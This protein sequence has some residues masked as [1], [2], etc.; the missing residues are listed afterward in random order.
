MR[1]LIGGIAMS[2]AISSGAV[3]ISFLCDR[4][5]KMQIDARS[6]EHF[7]CHPALR[8]GRSGQRDEKKRARHAVTKSLIAR[9]FDA[10]LLYI[11]LLRLAR[12][13]RR[14]LF[15]CCLIGAYSPP[16]LP[17][18]PLILVLGAYLHSTTIIPR[19]RLIS[20]R[21]MASDRCAVGML[22][23]FTRFM[24]L[25]LLIF[26]RILFLHFFIHHSYRVYIFLSHCL[27][28][29]SISRITH[30][31]FSLPFR[32]KQVYFAS[33]DTLQ[34]VRPVPRRSFAA[35]KSRCRHTVLLLHICGGI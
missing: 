34:P 17:C 15:C 24:I 2:M 19:R 28:R 21:A 6:R 27:S 1:F 22:D 10:K 13:T 35:H 14:Y 30:A 8:D 18:H 5:R 12:Q 25:R 29:F 4:R 23:A 16:R 32:H 26:T 7:Q 31:R 33:R 9:Q 20:R 3:D 11:A